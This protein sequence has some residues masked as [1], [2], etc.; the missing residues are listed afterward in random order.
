[1][2]NHNTPSHRNISNSSSQLPSVPFL[3]PQQFKIPSN[4]SKTSEVVTLINVSGIQIEMVQTGGKTIYRLP[5]KMSVNSLDPEKKIQVLKCI[6]KLHSDTFSKKVST[7][8]LNA[9]TNKSQPTLPATSGSFGNGLN[10][11]KPGLSSS[12]L[13]NNFKYPTENNALNSNSVDPILAKRVKSYDVLSAKPIAIRPRNT[14]PAS[15]ENVNKP[16]SVKEADHRAPGLE[17]MS[18]YFPQAL[19][20][21]QT[22]VNNYFL[23]ER[24]SL[25]EINFNNNLNSTSPSMALFSGN[26]Q[27][28]FNP[29]I[30]NNPKQTISQ[31]P[32]IVQS[33]LGN[34]NGT[35]TPGGSNLSANFSSFT[36][37]LVTGG[38]KTGNGMYT[39]TH[40]PNST[41][42]LNPHVLKS[43]GRNSTMQ[44]NK[45]LA[46]KRAQGKL[47]N[48][49]NRNT[50]KISNYGIYSNLSLSKQQLFNLKPT[51]PENVYDELIHKTPNSHHKGEKPAP[52]STNTLKR[53]ISFDHH[54][55]KKFKQGLPYSSSKKNHKLDSPL[56]KKLLTKTKN[57]PNTEIFKRSAYKKPL[58]E[59][60]KSLRIWN[61]GTGFQEIKTSASARSQEVTESSEQIKKKY[62]DRL[63]A[64]TQMLANIDT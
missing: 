44:I 33:L 60:V 50:H 40:R 24:P 36:G 19:H 51:K 6:D 34:G 20:S 2:N 39:P 62:S 21:I 49:E 59:K 9:D 11:A 46:N 63:S 1:M 53:P 17:G 13:P 41:N 48:S 18:S 31:S 27:M 15:K 26:D 45:K 16:L 10:P 22:P 29:Q 32:S 5:G 56:A 30:Y 4:D 43:Q 8:N 14:T 54:F 37:D 52:N 58:E 57:I 61:F 55:P 12:Y 3:M 28:F 23:P 35:L 7:H 38:N 42:D 47:S 25:Q 64:D